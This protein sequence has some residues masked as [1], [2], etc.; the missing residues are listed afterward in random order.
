MAQQLGHSNLLKALKWWGSNYSTTKDFIAENRAQFPLKE[1]K[2]LDQAQGIFGSF[3]C[4]CVDIS[5]VSAT[6]TRAAWLTAYSPKMMYCGMNSNF[7][8][9]LR[10]LSSGSMSVLLFEI[11]SLETICIQNS[12]GTSSPIGPG[13]VSMKMLTDAVQ[14]C[15]DFETLAEWVTRGLKFFFSQSNQSVTCSTCPWAIW[16]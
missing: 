14:T 12:V 8:A 3:D 2:G 4:K 5:D 13:D 15:N 9:Q 6:F 7:S 11:Q 1:K 10:W 16:F